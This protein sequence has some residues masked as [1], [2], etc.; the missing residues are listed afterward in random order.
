L[1]LLNSIDKAI[2]IMERYSTT[3]P[4]KRGRVIIEI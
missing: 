3:K 4:T 1:Y 2:A